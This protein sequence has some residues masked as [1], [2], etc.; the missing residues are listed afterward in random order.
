MTERAAALHVGVHGDDFDALVASYAFHRVSDEGQ[1]AMLLARGELMPC[2]VLI[3]QE[4]L[5]DPSN[6]LLPRLLRRNAPLPTELASAPSLQHVPLILLSRD[7][8]PSPAHW[9]AVD[10]VLTRPL[11]PAALTLALIDWRLRG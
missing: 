9:R 2:A 7:G 4:A 6:A 8:R 11:V 3:D 5:S 1:A 10:R